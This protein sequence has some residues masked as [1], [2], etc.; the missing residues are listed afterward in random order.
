MSSQKVSTT[1]TIKKKATT[2]T[3]TVPSSSSKVASS[4]STLSSAS[5]S[6]SASS[7]SSTIPITN[8]IH[9]QNLSPMMRAVRAVRTFQ[10]RVLLHKHVFAIYWS[11]IGA[12]FIYANLKQHKRMKKLYPDYSEV[13]KSTGSQFTSMKEQELSDVRSFNQKAEMMR[14]DLK[15]RMG[16]SSI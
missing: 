12:A 6:A 16:G 8:S 9:H 4:S 1:T 13:A 11:C 14:L 2:S 10:P 3:T 7:S 15:M 5:S